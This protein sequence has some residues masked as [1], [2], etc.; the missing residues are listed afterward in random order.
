MDRKRRT[1][2]ISLARRLRL[3]QHLQ[4]ALFVLSVTRG[5]IN[6]RPTSSFLNQSE[7]WWD[8]HIHEALLFRK[9]SAQFLLRSISES[10]LVLK[11]ENVIFTRLNFRNKNWAL[12]F[13]YY[14]YFST[15][16]SNIRPFHAK[17][18]PYEVF[19]WSNQ[20]ATQI[21]WPRKNNKIHDLWPS[22]TDTYR[23]AN[24][25]KFTFFE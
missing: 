20:N 1:V 8:H 15:I 17:M 7:I 9:P 4:G 2:Q 5:V 3:L 22:L 23:C 6:S 18:S 13:R 10:Y 21:F 12:G 14:F 24:I 11:R 16:S 19:S 25:M